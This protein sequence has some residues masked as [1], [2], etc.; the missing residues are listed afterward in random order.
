MSRIDYEQW[1]AEVA[2]KVRGAEAQA[3]WLDKFG[4]ATINYSPF[5]SFLSRTVRLRL[6]KF[7]PL[8]M[9][10]A[11]NWYDYSGA[12]QRSSKHALSAYMLFF[13]G[14]WKFHRSTLLTW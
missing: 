3:F 12:R 1:R 4:E 6:S 9:M 5:I 10:L 2:A 13:V 11:A 7:L 14:K 8:K